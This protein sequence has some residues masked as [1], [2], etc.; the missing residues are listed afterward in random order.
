VPRPLL[1]TA[2][3]VVTG[4]ACAAAGLAADVP[5]NALMIFDA[6]LAQASLSNPIYRAD[7]KPE[8]AASDLAPGRLSGRSDLIG[9]FSYRP[10]RFAELNR[11]ERAELL[12]DPGFRAFLVS[13]RE[14]SE[15]TEG[16]QPRPSAAA[17]FFSVSPE[18]ML[19]SGPVEVVLGP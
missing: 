11:R 10:R 8:A 1:R 9:R 15:R 6:Y 4:L 12:S 13:N 7:P 16:G 2:I 19:A 17:A 3:L 5:G 14:K 18:D